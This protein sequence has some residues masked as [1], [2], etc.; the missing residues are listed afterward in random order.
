MYDITLGIDWIEK[1][2]PMVFDFIHDTLKFNCGDTLID[3]ERK[4][5]QEILSNLK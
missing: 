5:R 4:D 3:L 2:S 1:F